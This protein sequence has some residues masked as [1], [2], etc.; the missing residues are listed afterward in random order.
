MVVSAIAVNFNILKDIYYWHFNQNELHVVGIV[1]RLIG[2][3]SWG[4]LPFLAHITRFVCSFGRSATQGEERESSRDSSIGLS[5]CGADLNGSLN[6]TAA[7]TAKTL[8]RKEDRIRSGRVWRWA[9]GEY[10]VLTMC[11]S[12]FMLSSRDVSAPPSF[13]CLHLFPLFLLR[14]FQLSLCP[15][16][17][18]N[19]TFLSLLQ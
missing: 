13:L 2:F 5:L 14:S 8:R 1:A 16:F 6:R 11:L 18:N 19:H 3:L 15:L 4:P 9:P 7:P 17:L 12:E 10:S